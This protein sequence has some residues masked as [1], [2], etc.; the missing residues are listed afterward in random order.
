MITDAAMAAATTIQAT[1]KRKTMVAAERTLVQDDA[2]AY[3]WQF[4]DACVQD[5]LFKRGGFRGG[6]Q[7]WKKRWI[8]CKDCSIYYYRVTKPVLLGTV[9]LD[10]A[11]TVEVVPQR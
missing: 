10:V 5:Y 4:R 7:N 3:R 8:V 6:R 11:T 9:H 2:G 1:N